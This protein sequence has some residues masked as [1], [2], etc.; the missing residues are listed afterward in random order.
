MGEHGNRIF[1]AA[2]V[3]IGLLMLMGEL[4][5]ELLR[6]IWPIA[7]GLAGFAVLLHYR[8]NKDDS[9]KVFTGVTLLLLGA[10]LLFVVMDWLSI[11]AHWPFF[12]AAPG[13]GL[14]AMARADVRRR[15][16]MVPGW[17]AIGAAAVLY[18]FTLGLFV[19][20]LEV[21]FTLLALVLKVAVPL[22]LIALGAW[23]LFQQNERRE[24]SREVPEKVEPEKGWGP[25]PEGDVAAAGVGS[26][27]PPQTD[28]DTAAETEETPP[29][30]DSDASGE[31]VEESTDPWV[32]PSTRHDEPSPAGGEPHPPIEDAEI[33]EPGPD[34]PPVDEPG[35]DAPEPDT[36]GD[37]EPE[38]DDPERRRD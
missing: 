32:T 14:L 8:R 22:G 21:V 37:D 18:F 12:I 35:P 3:L 19:D 33:E 13:L 36:P 10:F 1:G 30:E 2:I 11:R 4:V 15:D 17:M 23:M 5:S 7:L 16:A 29:Y 26:A 31:V 38:I 28:D 34:D 20:L 6:L 24:S 9:G 25:P 27:V